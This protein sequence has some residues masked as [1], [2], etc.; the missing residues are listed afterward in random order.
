MVWQSTIDS[1]RSVLSLLYLLLTRSSQLGSIANRDAELT[2]MGIK[3]AQMV[4]LF[5]IE[6][7]LYACVAGWE[8]PTQWWGS[9]GLQ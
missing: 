2:A 7:A 1:N 3:Q 6:A 9:G 8:Y 5:T 4:P